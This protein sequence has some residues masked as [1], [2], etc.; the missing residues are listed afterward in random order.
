[1]LSSN[2]SAHL[3][4]R[5]AWHLVIFDHVKLLYERLGRPRSAT[6]VMANR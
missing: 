1:M 6:T 2:A 5:F 3:M 4:P